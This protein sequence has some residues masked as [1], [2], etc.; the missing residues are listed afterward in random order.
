MNIKDYLPK[1]KM[2]FESIALL[3]KLG[4][5]DLSK[6]IPEL[7]EWLQDVNWPIASQICE[8]LMPLEDNLIP[9]IK[10]V[11]NSNDSQW[12]YSILTNLVSNF[13]ITNKLLLKDELLRLFNNP[14]FDDMEEE[15]DSLSKEILDS[16]G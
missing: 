8:L 4:I 14:S 11:L 3:R 15:I 10:K 7:F 1:D 5:S 6:L 16:M 9:H 2:D 12:K 13:S